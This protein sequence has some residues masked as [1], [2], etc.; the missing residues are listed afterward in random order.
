MKDKKRI[1]AQKNTQ[2]S[3]LKLTKS[4]HCWKCH[5]QNKHKY[6]G[7]PFPPL[8]VVCMKQACSKTH[9]GHYFS[10]SLPAPLNSKG[11]TQWPPFLKAMTSASYPGGF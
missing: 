2:W 1:A 4:V 7:K 6:V 10:C 9:P 8:L 3:K 5:W 11:L